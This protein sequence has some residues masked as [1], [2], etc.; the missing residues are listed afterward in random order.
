M[1]VSPGPSSEP[2]EVSRVA[3]AM[4]AM[5]RESPRQFMDLI[6]AFPEVPYRTLLLAWGEVREAHRLARE[7]DGSY[8]LP[9]SP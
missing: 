8:F 1:S 9:P 2:G 3:A 7:E 4:V 6:R 5:L